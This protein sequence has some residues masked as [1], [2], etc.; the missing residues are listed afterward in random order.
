MS[1]NGTLLH[2][3]LSEIIYSRK[4]QPTGAIPDI[5]FKFYCDYNETHAYRLLHWNP[6]FWIVIK[7]QIIIQ[8]SQ[9]LRGNKLDTLREMKTIRQRCGSRLMCNVIIRLRIMW[10]EFESGKEKLE[11][12]MHP[13]YLIFKYI[14]NDITSW[15][16][17]A[18]NQV[19]RN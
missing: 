1:N 6:M 2:V 19:Y 7:F 13:Q 11:T 18:M 16:G 8:I 15:L 17:I 4:P 5:D 9:F 14:S 10:L 12:L 3:A